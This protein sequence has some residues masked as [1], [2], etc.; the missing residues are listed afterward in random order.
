M[1]NIIYTKSGE[2]E[3]SKILSQVRSE[4]EFNVVKMYNFDEN[5]IE[6]TKKDIQNAILRPSK[7][8]R[9]LVVLRLIGILYAL[10]GLIVFAGGF[11][12][13][14]FIKNIEFGPA[15]EYIMM[16]GMIFL[17][18]LSVVV[19]SHIMKIASKY[20]N[21][22][23]YITISEKAR[24][25]KEIESIVEVF[26]KRDADIKEKLNFLK[27]DISNLDDKAVKHAEHDSKY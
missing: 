14:F 18:G 16:G 4:I 1:P 17:G 20:S 2:E 25:E 7:K 3:M 24:K 11:G 23:I 10:T 13:E 12:Y 19:F 22:S 26:I 9:K 6:I 8:E 5:E 15:S 21:D 27:R